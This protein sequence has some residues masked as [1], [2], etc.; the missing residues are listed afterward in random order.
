MERQV[1]EDVRTAYSDWQ[2]AKK[3]VQVTGKTLDAAESMYRLTRLQYE[4]GMTSYFFLQDKENALTNAEYNYTAA[5]FELYLAVNRLEKV[6][7][8]REY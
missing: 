7:S 4:Q 3:N 5:V 2:L 8:R 6:W 1:E